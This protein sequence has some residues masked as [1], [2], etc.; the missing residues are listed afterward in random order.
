M[1]NTPKPM[2]ADELAAIRA[3]ADRME[4]DHECPDDPKRAGWCA[5]QPCGTMT[6]VAQLRGLTSE[7]AE[8]KAR[9]EITDTKA[10]YAHKVYKQHRGL[11]EV[12]RFR[13]ALEAAIN[14]EKL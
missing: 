12:E 7:N 10:F 5:K 8:L 6:T 9:L 13:F 14:P 2:T 1:N 4:R 11:S 3:R